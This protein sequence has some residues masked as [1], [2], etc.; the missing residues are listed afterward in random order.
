MAAFHRQAGGTQPSGPY[1][2]GDSGDASRLGT[3]D[4]VAG[5]RSTFR[6]KDV[7][8]LSKVTRR[9]GFHH[10]RSVSRRGVTS[11]RVLMCIDQNATPKGRRINN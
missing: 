6:T 9:I 8:T 11:D 7:S 3:S 2:T 4:P 1:S 10:A 5:R